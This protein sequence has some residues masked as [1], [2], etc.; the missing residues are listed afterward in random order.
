MDS[1]LYKHWR[2]IFVAPFHNDQRTITP[3]GQVRKWS[4][5]EQPDGAI[6]TTTTHAWPSVSVKRTDCIENNTFS[7]QFYCVGV[8]IRIF[9]YNGLK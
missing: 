6:C 8:G 2:C 3:Y 9:R 1:S 7:F 4:T 5:I